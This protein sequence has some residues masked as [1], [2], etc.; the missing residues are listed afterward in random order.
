[1]SSISCIIIVSR[2]I[3]NIAC[4][5]YDQVSPKELR[6]WMFKQNAIYVYF[7]NFIISFFLICFDMPILAIVFAF[8]LYYFAIT[9]THERCWLLCGSPYISM[10]GRR[11]YRFIVPTNKTLL[12]FCCL[13]KRKFMCWE[14]LFFNILYGKS[15][16]CLLRV[17]WKENLT[18]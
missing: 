15:V 5:Q 16:G 2:K 13:E 6:W 9:E 1:M 3:M 4:L 18:S 17:C 12:S 11:E 14:N 10:A 8:F 7:C